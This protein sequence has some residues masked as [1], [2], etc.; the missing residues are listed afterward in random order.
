M[1]TK[2]YKPE[3]IVNLLCRIEVEIA[4]GKTTPQAAPKSNLRVGDHL[5]V[6]RLGQQF[7][8]TQGLYWPAAIFREADFPGRIPSSGGIS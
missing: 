4:N 5:G 2:R 1:S 7:R 8:I 6:D 3:Q